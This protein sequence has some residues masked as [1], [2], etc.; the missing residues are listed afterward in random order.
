MQQIKGVNRR[1]D[2]YKVDQSLLLDGGVLGKTF[3]SVPDG[4]ATRTNTISFW[5]KFYKLPDGTTSTRQYFISLYEDSDNRQH[6]GL[7]NDGYLWAYCQKGGQVRLNVKTR[8]SFEDASGWYHIVQRVDTYDQEIE[9]C[10]IYVNGELQQLQSGGVI[11][12][13]GSPLMFFSALGEHRIGS[14]FNDGQAV[15]GYIA[16]VYGTGGTNLDF[17]ASR[18]GQENSNTGAWDP[19]PF[20]GD[21][22]ANGFHLNFSD[23]D[24]I[25]SDSSGNGN[26][27]STSGITSLSLSPDSPANNYSYFMPYP[28]WRNT[29]FST[30]WESTNGGKTIEQ[31][32]SAGANASYSSTISFKTGRFWKA[33]RIDELTS[34]SGYTYVGFASLNSDNVRL[35]DR[36]ICVQSSTGA[37]KFWDGSSPTIT[38][39]DLI[40]GEGDII[41]FSVHVEL[42]RVAIYKNGELG[43]I[44][45]EHQWY[46]TGA[47]IVFG[48]EFNTPTTS[49]KVTMLDDGS[50]DGSMTLCSNNLIYD[51]LQPDTEYVGNGDNDGPFVYTC[52]P[53]ESFNLDG[54]LIINAPDYNPLDT[55]WSFLSNGLKSTSTSANT[56]GS[57]YNITDVVLKEPF[58]YSRGQ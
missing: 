20:T 42:K 44:T 2:G 54:S 41:G 56:N 47:G 23:A 1:D 29:N 10:Q 3:S 12:D 26:D 11:G 43:Y 30:T 27:F 31:Q 48:A 53:V 24:N 46:D 9:R 50:P 35:Q 58:K 25:G 40:Y 33:F 19:I 39:P 13:Q 49:G 52:G 55:R 22:G 57:T 5:V 28:T 36:G 6:F 51:N 45:S 34:G 14:Y 32:N 21:Y 18:F 38:V 17:P 37:V 7:D 4:A 15:R 16:D 8:M